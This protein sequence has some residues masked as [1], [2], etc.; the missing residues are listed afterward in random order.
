MAIPTSSSGDEFGCASALRAPVEPVAKPRGWCA[1]CER[2]IQLTKA[3][4]L[5]HHGGPVGAGMWND[6][7]SYRCNGAGREPSNPPADREVI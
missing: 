7:R 4:K 6:Y 1:E 5:R 3:G 2:F